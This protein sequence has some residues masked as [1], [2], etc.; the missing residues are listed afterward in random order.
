MEASNAAFGAIEKD[1]L[2]RQ[3]AER[4][5]SLI[6]EKHLQPGDRLPPERELAATMQVSRPSVREAL[7]ALSVLNIVEIRQGAGT[8]VTSLEP[9]LLVEP[10]DFILSLDTST[11]PQLFEARKILEV[12]I[13]A[14]AAAR[15]TDEEVAALEHS[16]A[17]SEA[18]L[19]ANDTDS[20]IRNDLDLHR[21]IVRA[22]HNP[23]LNRL[24]DSISQLGL[25]SRQQTVRRPLTMPLTVEDHR[26]IIAALKARDSQAASQAMLDHLNHVE[27]ALREAGK[28]DEG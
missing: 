28:K 2:P 8:F 14:M 11:L 26:A 15:I 12:G 23:I 21:R 27:Q 18:A 22:T 13:A 7:Q 3:I 25:V 6:K 5:L 19:I 9:A 4:I 20:F 10:L 24:L 1:V 17:Q 16:L